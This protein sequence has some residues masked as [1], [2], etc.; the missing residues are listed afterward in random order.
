MPTLTPGSGLATSARRAAFYDVDGTLVSVNV[1]H[2]YAYY[3][4]TDRGL[5]NRLRR[6]GKLAASLPVFGVLETISR[7]A[8]N[9]QFF[10]SY[11]GLSDDRLWLLGEEV[12]DEVIRPNLY[13][14]AREM[15]ARCRE[16]GLWQVLVT[17]SLE[18]VTA[19]LARYLGVDDF[20]ANRL[21]MDGR[22][23]TGR[24]I[25]PIVA[26]AHKAEL[27]RAY[28]KQHGIDLSESFAYADSESDYPML[29]TVGR[30]CAMNPDRKLRQ[31]AREYSWPVVDLGR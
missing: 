17:G 25:P 29:C 28:A 14:G 23:A 5:T 21:E 4:A 10:K 3:A 31:I 9:E 6:L 1:L 24:V 20:I 26:G 15:V 13:P 2:A 11:R 22:H 8:F 30:P 18:H 12:F 27:I 16:Q 7:K 19:P